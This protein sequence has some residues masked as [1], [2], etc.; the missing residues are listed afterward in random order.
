MLVA[1]FAQVTAHHTNFDVT[2]DTI[3]HIPVVV[4][5]WETK[6][7]VGCANKIIRKNTFQTDSLIPKWT[8]ID[9]YYEHSGYDRGHM[10]PCEANLCQGHGVERECF[11]MSNMLPQAHKLNI[12][13]WK[14]LETLCINWAKSMDSIKIWAG[15]I[16]EIGKIKGIVSIPKYCFK[17]IYIKKQKQFYAYLFTNSPDDKVNRNPESTV[18]NIEQLTGLKFTP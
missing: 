12:G 9:K 10:D 6:A 7:K 16:G 14:S 4:S 13:S 3:K 5:W 8:N 2:F 17:I 15:P 1:S 18:E 11:V